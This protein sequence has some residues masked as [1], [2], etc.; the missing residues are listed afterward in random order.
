M[1]RLTTL[2]L[3]TFPSAAFAA[4]T[5]AQLARTPVAIAPPPSSAPFT[6]L[7]NV[8]GDF[9][10]LA[11]VPVRP[12]IYVNDAAGAHV[13]ALNVYLNAIQH[14]DATQTIVQ[15]FRTLSSP[16]AIARYVAP[17]GPN[18]DRL[19]VVCQH[20]DALAVHDR[21]TG[22]LLEIVYLPAQP[23]DIVVDA[24]N[25]RAFVSSIGEDAVV[26]IDLSN[27]T[28]PPVRY[29]IPSRKPMFLSIAPGGEVLVAPM[30]SGNNSGVDYL[31]DNN[32]SKQHTFNAHADTGG[33]LDLADPTVSNGGLPDEDL[34]FIDR[35]AGVARPVVRG[36]GTVL[37]AQQVVSSSTG[38]LF[39]WQLNVDMNN[40][41]ANKQS[42]PAIQGEI[43]FNR[44]T[45]M[46]ITLPPP[47]TP[48]TAQP[49][50]FIQ[51]DD[52]NPTQPGIQ[53]NRARSVGH[54]YAMH[55]SP[56]GYV[57]IAGLLSDNLTILDPAGNFVIEWDLPDGC[58]PRQVMTDP[59]EQLIYT[60]C[61][62]LNT[63][64]VDLLGVP[65]TDLTSYSLGYDPT[66]T[67]IRIGRILFFDGSFSEHNNASCATCHVEGG[68]DFVAWNLSEPLLDE[69]GPMTTQSLFAVNRTGTPYWRGAQ[70]N[71]LLDF[72]QAFVD[73]LGGT[74][75]TPAQFADFEAFVHSLE[76]P[77]NPYEN[78]LR[79]VDDTIQIPDELS[80]FG[81][82]PTGSALAG[83][84][85]FNVGCAN[86]HTMPVGGRDDSMSTGVGFGE[87]QQNRHFMKVGT[88][89]SLPERGLQ[90]PV[91]VKF[92]NN[93][94]RD[95][96]RLGVG[97]AHAGNPD[98][99]FDFLL[100]FIGAGLQP[101]VDV[102]NFLFQFDNGLA[103]STRIPLKLDGS[104]ASWIPSLI[105]AYQEPQAV[106]G[107]S[108]LAVFGE[109]TIG[110]TRRV[111]GWVL[112]TSV[113]PPQYVRD[114]GV[115]QPLSFFVSQAVAGDW[116][117]FSGVPVGT[118]R[119]F[120]VDFDNDDL[121]NALEV[122]GGLTNP[123][124]DGDG[125]LDGHEVNN[126]GDA[127]N[128]AV[129]PTDITPPNFAFTSGAPRWV[130]AKSGRLGFVTDE[131]TVWALFLTPPAGSGLPTKV[132]FDAN[133]ARRHSVLFRDLRPNTT[134]TTQ[135]WVFDL[136]SNMPAQSTA[137]NLTTMPHSDGPATAVIGGY[138]WT[139][140]QLSPT[141]GTFTVD[142]QVNQKTS[143]G[144]PLANRVVVARAVVGGNVAGQ[145]GGPGITTPLPPDF[146]TNGVPYSTLRGVVAGPYVVS[147][148]SNAAGVAQ[149][150]FTLSGI[151]LGD[152]IDLSIEAIAESSGNVCA[153]VPNAEDFKNQVGN[154]PVGWSL[155]DTQANLRRSSTI[156]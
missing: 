109:T 111:A 27:L 82:I 149:L 90:P 3:L 19:L 83:Q 88:L 71:G 147:K 131:L 41:D 113:I 68:V 115:A 114:D 112:D 31:A 144:S 81:P 143:L 44:V 22:Q 135:L 36:T 23:A 75:M 117:V 87:F 43:A 95:F 28:A 116:F 55:V 123:D 89:L 15:S 102:A 62:G 12:M 58:V 47:A 13:Y 52:T 7:D 63:I 72:N 78:V 74:S 139:V 119:T 127:L 153:A 32:G 142:V 140:N 11:P 98:N 70:L 60:Y 76:P 50:H 132:F 33:I 107:H 46:P 80:A 145:T 35:A 86:C 92:P 49:Q 25:A 40:K 91:Q 45:R 134:Y 53:Y 84:G 51:L 29:A 106:A 21:Q 97:L 77:P 150:Q 69:K 128:P 152:Q 125:W 94:I 17:S 146:C 122:T 121:L 6:D 124:T 99:I 2:L 73:L 93:Q 100:L 138:N 110:G 141:S 39:L 79:V 64:D 96:P 126:G 30:L 137:F 34:F 85:L 18:P 65:P 129:G 9:V 56:T 42:R 136:G 54:P 61:S 118:A 24:A 120:A 151:Q 1:R 57:L 48:P 130:N 104:T 38:A 59:S 133:P 16:V 105:Q 103:P 67:N 148:P 156:F 155:P 14:L 37:L 66:P 154:F 101:T 20:A 5:P 10:N 8:E 108:E 4:P 26:E